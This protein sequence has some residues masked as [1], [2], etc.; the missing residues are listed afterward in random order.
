MRRP[1]TVKKYT[2]VLCVG[3]VAFFAT[4]ALRQG[5]YL[6][7]FELAAYDAFVRLVP[8]EKNPPPWITL[9]KI[10]DQDIQELGHWPLTDAD[11]TQSLETILTAGPRAVGLDIYRDIPVPPG[12]DKLNRLFLENPQVIGIMKVGDQGIAPLPAIA[13]TQQ[14]A[15]GD[16]LSD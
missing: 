11:I 2:L 3:C 6:E 8:K 14:A 12:R 7:F 1:Q 16:I 4:F 13:G 9:I 15:F 10:T 5:G